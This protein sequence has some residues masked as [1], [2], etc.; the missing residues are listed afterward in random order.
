MNFLL[1]FNL[2]T[3]LK[4]KKITVNVFLILFYLESPCTNMLGMVSGQILDSQISVWPEM[5]RGWLP[6]QARLLTGRT[7]WVA[8]LPSVPHG[9]ANSSW[10]GLDLGF[11]HWV[12]A[13]I[14]QGG[15]HRD[16]F[17][18][19]RRFKLAYSTNGSDWS[20]IK[21]ENSNKSQVKHSGRGGGRERGIGG[22][23]YTVI[24]KENILIF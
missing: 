23:I 1:N 5:E 21:E 14:L 6:E 17:L 16:K 20:Y 11:T 12:T 3:V 19:V 10:L 2:V 7:G 22:Q 9:T 15:K 4:S 18:F 8:P 13:V 24:R